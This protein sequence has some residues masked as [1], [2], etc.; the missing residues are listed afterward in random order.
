MWSN[1]T[2]VCKFADKVGFNQ[3]LRVGQL[4]DPDYVE[5]VRNLDPNAPGFEILLVKYRRYVGIFIPWFTLM[6]TWWT[7]AIK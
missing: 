4:L 3:F 1:V 5:A 2:G 7:L 6:I